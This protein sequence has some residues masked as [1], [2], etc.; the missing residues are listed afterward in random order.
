MAE[1]DREGLREIAEQGVALVRAEFG[2]SLDWSLD[3]LTVLD[4][5]CVELLCDGPLQGERLDLWWKVIGAYT[6]EVIVRAFDGQW[7]THEQAGG[8]YAVQALSVTGFPF[9]LVHRILNGEPFKSLASFARALPVIN[10]RTS[11]SG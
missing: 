11:T 8:A 10:E 6:G 9:G 2:R 1:V 3:S 7:I 5:V 4:E